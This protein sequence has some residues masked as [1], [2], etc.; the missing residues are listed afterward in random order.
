[1]TVGINLEIKT[2][3]DSKHIVV[4]TAVLIVNELC[5]VTFKGQFYSDEEQTSDINKNLFWLVL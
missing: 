5:S 3:E 2:E 1:M 4:T